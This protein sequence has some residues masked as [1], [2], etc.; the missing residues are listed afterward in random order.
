MAQALGLDLIFVSGIDGH[1]VA[2]LTH[3]GYSRHIN[4]R[5]YGRL[6]SAGEVGCYANHLRVAETFVASGE[7]VC[8][9]LEDD[10][11]IADEFLD[12]LQ[13]FQN[14]PT[15]YLMMRF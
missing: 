6:L 4:R 8:I 12:F 11:Y 3:L 9:V 10:A 5:Q 15:R 7:D 13:K 14:S 1:S 2:D